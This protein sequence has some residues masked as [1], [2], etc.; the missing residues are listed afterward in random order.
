[1]EE[2]AVAAESVGEASDG[3]MGDPVLAGDLS[4]AGAGEESVESW[5]C[6]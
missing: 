2:Q 4:E 1:M 5:I 3:A 6:G